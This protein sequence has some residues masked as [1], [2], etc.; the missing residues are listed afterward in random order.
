MFIKSWIL[1]A[2][3]YFWIQTVF[4]C[5]DSWI[6]NYDNISWKR[7]TF[8]VVYLFPSFHAV[9]NQFQ[10]YKAS[11]SSVG[12]G[13]DQE[14]VVHS[15][16]WVRIPAVRS[17]GFVKKKIVAT[18]Q[19]RMRRKYGDWSVRW[20]RGRENIVPGE[21]RGREREKEVRSP[22]NGDGGVGGKQNG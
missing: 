10:F 1:I 9:E 2:F 15:H 18:K 13:A 20:E 16:A 12:R 7:K 14:T 21:G 8:C 5:Y 4:F 19:C 3:Y 11:S 17:D 6:V 22:W